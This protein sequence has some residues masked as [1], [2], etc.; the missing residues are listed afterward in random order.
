MR[1]SRI[2]AHQ[3]PSPVVER[4]GAEWMEM[5]KNDKCMFRG[6]SGPVPPS[7]GQVIEQ[8]IDAYDH[9]NNEVIGKYF[10]AV[11]NQRAHIEL[12]KGEGN[13]PSLLSDWADVTFMEMDKFLIYVCNVSLRKVPAIRDYLSVG[14]LGNKLVRVLSNR[15]RFEQIKHCLM[16]CNPTPEENAADRIPKFWPFHDAVRGIIQPYWVPNPK[17]A[18]DESQQQCPHRN[19]CVSHCAK[20]NKPLSNYIKMISA[21]DS[22]N[23]YCNAFVVDERLPNVSVL[24]LVMA[25]VKQ[26]P[27]V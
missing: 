12:A 22:I 1:H 26:Y 20:T 9:F 4:G 3:E 10:V 21:H 25:V 24:D 13:Y 2:F 14:I 15:H 16:V 23:G 11:T 17:Q 7:D 19:S 18:L 5:T 6:Q 8:P 27:D